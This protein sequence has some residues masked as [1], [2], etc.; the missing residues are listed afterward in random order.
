MRQHV[1]THTHTHTHIHFYIT[2][3][4]HVKSLFDRALHQKPHTHAHTLMCTHTHTHTHKKKNRCFRSVHPHPQ[5][6]P[7]LRASSSLHNIPSRT[8]ARAPASFPLILSKLLLANFD[9][10]SAFLIVRFSSSFSFFLSFCL[11]LLIYLHL[12]PFF[13]T[14][15]CCCQYPTRFE[16]S[17]EART[18]LVR[19]Q[20]TRNAYRLLNKTRNGIKNVRQ[21]LVDFYIDLN[22]YAYTQQLLTKKK[23]KRNWK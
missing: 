17:A 2:Y 14:F 18:H 8:I 12:F 3:A 20:P 6:P 7:P 1:A 16:C 11:S 4:Q 22:R 9:R 10:I 23:F 19:T 21:R 15:V 5:T 13:F